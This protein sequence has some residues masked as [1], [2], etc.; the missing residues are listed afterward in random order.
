[1]CSISWLRRLTFTTVAVAPTQH[2]LK[3]RG[4]ANG[5]VFAGGGLG[6]AVISYSIEALIQHIGL[7]WAFRV[8]CLLVATT[9]LPAAYLIRERVDD[10]YDAESFDTLAGDLAGYLRTGLDGEPEGLDVVTGEVNLLCERVIAA[11]VVVGVLWRDK[12]NQ[13]NSQCYW[14]EDGEPLWQG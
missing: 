13:K 10:W 12:N 7:A 6:G 2:F 3:K 1:M 11:A 14:H 8:H 5:I 4:L 9:G